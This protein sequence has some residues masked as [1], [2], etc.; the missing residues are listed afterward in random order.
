M[1]EVEILGAPGCLPFGRAGRGWTSW[2]CAL[3]PLLRSAVARLAEATQACWLF[4]G[5]DAEDPTGSAHVEN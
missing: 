3:K 5:S 4:V 2:A 1:K